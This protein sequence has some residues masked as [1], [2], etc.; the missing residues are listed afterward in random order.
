VFSVIAWIQF[1]GVWD[2]YLWPSLVI[3]DNNKAP[4]ALAI[5]TVMGNFMNSSLMDRYTGLSQNSAA[6]GALAAGLSWNGLMVLALLQTIPIFL[7]FI[8]CRE[9]LLKGVKISGFK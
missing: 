3:V 2:S 6:Q 9:Y 1:S 8:L 5:Y 4:T 7:M